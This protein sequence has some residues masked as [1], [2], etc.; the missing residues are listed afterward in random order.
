[1]KRSTV[2][3]LTVAAIAAKS[4]LA[5]TELAATVPANGTM[6]AAAPETVQLTFSE[7]VR[8]T[9][10]SIQKDGERKQ[11]LGPL[12]AAATEEFSVALP[13]TIEDGHYVVTWRALSEDTHVMTGEFM[14]AVGVDGS[15]D[16][17][18]NHA[19]MPGRE[20]HEAAAGDHAGEHHNAH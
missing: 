2:I 19:D 7:P 14:F 17:H 8:L 20:L 5:H 6:I 15:H 16:A 13:A 11:S 3:L 4:A 10:L 12:T 9:A 1:V 18:M